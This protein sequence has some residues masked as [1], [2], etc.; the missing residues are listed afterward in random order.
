MVIL[1]D[2]PAYEIERDGYRLSTDRTKLDLDLVHSYLAGDSYW[3]RGLDRALFERA[4]EG[5]VPVAIYAPDGSLATFARVV[6]DLAIFAYLRDVFTLPAHRGRGLAA[7]LAEAIRQHPEL[8]SVSTWML[9]TRDAHAVYA[10]A[11][12]LPVP[13]PEYYMSVPKPDETP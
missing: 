12:F 6:T 3:A 7:W 5:S 10:K 11:G 2:L 8:A 13:H 4:L 9:A 1:R